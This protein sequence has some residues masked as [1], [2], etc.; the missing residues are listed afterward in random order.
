LPQTAV[1]GVGP[2]RS[3]PPTSRPPL[4]ARDLGR[5]IPHDRRTNRKLGT[6]AYL[7]GTAFARIWARA[8]TADRPSSGE[9]RRGTACWG[10]AQS[11]AAPHG[12]EPSARGHV[13]GR[14]TSA[15]RN[16][17]CRCPAARLRA[18]PNEA[19]GHPGRVSPFGRAGAITARSSHASS[20]PAVPSTCPKHRFATD[21]AA[22]HTAI[23]FA[24]DMRC[25]VLDCGGQFR[26]RLSSGT[27]AAV[28]ARHFRSRGC[29]CRRAAGVRKPLR[30][31]HRPDRRCPPA[32][33]TWLGRP[34]QDAQAAQ[35]PHCVSDCRRGETA[36]AGPPQS[37]ASRPQPIADIAAR[38]AV[39]G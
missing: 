22:A 5:D 37:C 14:R 17:Q 32:T 10:Q 39:L 26:F 16:R 18:P 21:R 33:P 31:P 13:V 29:P 3:S 20:P 25:P 1:P 34:A 35:R 12:P 15:T 2:R 38:G 11:D 4:P 23:W 19:G 9:G 6:S 7:S 36:A 30:C 8:G 28:S 27:A 24:S